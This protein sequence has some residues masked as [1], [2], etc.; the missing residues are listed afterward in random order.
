[1]KLQTFPVHP[2]LFSSFIPTLRR[3]IYSATDGPFA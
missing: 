2:F 3:Q 1:M